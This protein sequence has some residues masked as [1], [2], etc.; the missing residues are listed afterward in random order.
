[1]G[2]SFDKTTCTIDQTY[3]YRFF[4][5]FLTSISNS[6]LEEVLSSQNEGTIINKQNQSNRKF[7]SQTLTS[8]T[9]KELTQISLDI[10]QPISIRCYAVDGLFLKYYFLSRNTLPII[11]NST[12]ANSS[13]PKEEGKGEG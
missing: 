3:D 6:N 11:D 4:N 1:M 5:L 12:S 8:I 9:V 10:K 2:N 13:K 7:L